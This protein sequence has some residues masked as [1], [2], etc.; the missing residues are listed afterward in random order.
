MTIFGVPYLYGTTPNGGGLWTVGNVPEVFDYFLP[1]RWRRTPRVKLSLTHEVYRTRTRDHIHIVYRR[2]RVGERPPADP[3]YEQG[4]RIRAYGHNSPFE[5]AA[6]AEYLRNV[7]IPTIYPRAIYRTGHESIRAVYLRDERR[8][9]S[10]ARFVT[11]GPDPQPALSPRHDYYII[12]GEFRGVDAQ[13]AY[14]P[15]GHWGFIDLRKA[16]DD[17]LISAAE[18]NA[19]IARARERLGRFGLTHKVLEEYELLLLFDEQGRFRRE[20]H[21]DFETLLCMDVLSAHD[22]NLIDEATYR[23]LI[24]RTRSRLS[25]VGCE[26]LNLSGNHLLLAMTPDGVLRTDA[27]GQVEITVCNFELIVCPSVLA[28]GRP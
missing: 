14:R 9:L 8:Y 2:S 26:A 1:D 23:R 7:G 5:E 6:L 25:A 16:L 3:F 12:W 17:E 24:E 4:K 21:G 11:P 27:E 19:V 20:A 22:F 13:R 28:E 15:V 10:H 18:H